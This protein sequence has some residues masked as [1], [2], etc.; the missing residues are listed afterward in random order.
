MP[1]TPQHISS[2]L[3]HQSHN[4]D[5]IESTI[6]QKISQPPPQASVPSDNAASTLPTADTTSSELQPDQPIKPYVSKIGILT[7]S[8]PVYHN[9][10]M[11]AKRKDAQGSRLQ[12]QGEPLEPHQ[13][14]QVS[15]LSLD[16]GPNE[17]TSEQQAETI[18][19]LKP[20]SRSTIQ[21]QNIT[22]EPILQDGGVVLDMKSKTKH[23]STK[24]QFGIRSRN[25]PVDA[26]KCLY[27]ALTLM[28]DCQWQIRP[29]K[30]PT[31]P[32][33][34]S[35]PYPVTVQG[36][37]HL[38]S[39][40]Q[41]L[42]ESPEKERH[43]RRTTPPPQHDNQHHSNPN[44]PPGDQDILHG[45][46]HDDIDS[47]ADDEVD[48][49][50]IP[51]GY[52]PKDPWCINVRWEKKGMAPPGTTSTSSAQSSAVDLHNNDGQ[53]RRGSLAM[54]SLGSAAGS[55]TSVSHLPEGSSTAVTPDT[56]CFVYLDLQIY[57]LETDIYLV[58]FKNAGY[59]PIVGE[60]KVGGRKG[61]SVTEYVGNGQRKNEKNVTSPQPFMDLANKLVIHLAKGAH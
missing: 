3:A 36:A 42:S 1:P 52:V 51:E 21:L 60:R 4:D 32:N 28:G 47:E 18:R 19:H 45:S 26:I 16:V 61:E 48:S 46:S 55:A 34:E 39:A 53:G 35:G 27:R 29:P 40:H 17:Q 23:K 12:E 31:H 43:L 49:H 13:V 41:N 33:G 8:L 59:E 15:K 14:T 2:P 37:T 44:N 30:D 7:S 10:F 38:P 6:D 11:D 5:L 24:W 20:H 25:E 58:D 54:N 57:V 22:K 50:I 9:A 56:A